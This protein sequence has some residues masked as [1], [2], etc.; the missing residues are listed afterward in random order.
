MHID[1]A[2]W[3]AD[4]VNVLS[5]PT[6]SPRILALTKWL[7][8]LSSADHF[9][10][11]IYEGSYKPYALLDSFD[12]VNRKYFVDDYQTAPYLLDPFYHATKKTNLEGVLSMRNLAPDEFFSSEYYLNYYHRLGLCEE[13]G[14]FLE[15]SES[16]SAVLSLM[17]SVGS[18]KFTSTEIDLLRNTFSVVK[19]VTNTAW[20]SDRQVSYRPIDQRDH[21][22]QQAYMDFGRGVLTE[23][24]CEVS[25]LLLQ[26]H[27]NISTA[28]TLG[29]SPGTVKVHRKNLYDKLDIGSQSELLALF[30]EKMRGASDN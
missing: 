8:T 26:G 7:K 27:S 22:L 21:L 13:L 3:T 25:R 16:T 28:K 6:G 24:E 11:F 1:I 23:R 29:I 10:L 4:V 17:R 20:K 12:A 18:S 5:Q 19:Y 14:F 30:L 2:N 9:V 15:L